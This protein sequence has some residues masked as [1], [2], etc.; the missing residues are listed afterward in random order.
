MLK[1]NS[2]VKV[3][4]CDH[5]KFPSFEGETITRNYG[6]IFEVKKQNGKLGIVWKGRAA[7]I[8]NFRAETEKDFSN[9]GWKITRC[10]RCQPETKREKKYN[11]MA[12]VDMGQAARY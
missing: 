1:E 4:F 9:S 6:K 11:S 8:E 5:R 7:N 2:K 12:F 10:G 3:H